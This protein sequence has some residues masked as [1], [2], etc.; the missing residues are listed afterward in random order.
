M[1][2]LK[3]LWILILVPVFGGALMAQT[4]LATIT[5]QVTDS[6]GAVVP[7]VKIAGRERWR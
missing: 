6:V 1:R 3:N 7:G 5:G 4:T 2:R